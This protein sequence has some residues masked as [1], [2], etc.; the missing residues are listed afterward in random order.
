MRGEGGK[1]TYKRRQLLDQRHSPSGSY[2]RLRILSIERVGIVQQSLSG[3]N[4]MVLFISPVLLAL[5]LL[6]PN[7][8]RR[9]SRN[10]KEG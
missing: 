7:E 6:S 3:C 2:Q 10:R 8:A 5:N 1:E 4:H 9:Q